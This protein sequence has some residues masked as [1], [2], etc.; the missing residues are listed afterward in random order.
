MNPNHAAVWI[1][2]ASAGELRIQTG[3]VGRAARM[4]HRLTIAMTRWSATVDWE[5]AEPVAAKLAVEVDSLEVLCGQGGLKALSAAEKSVVRSNALK[6][7][8][9]NRFPRILFVA[10]TG[11]SIAETAGGYRLTG[12][13]DIMG[14]ARQ[15]VIDLRTEELGDAWSISAESTVR[16]SDYGVKPYSLFM[17]SV[18]VADDVTVTL[19]ARHAKDD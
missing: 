16:Q 2:D 17:G 7:L 10:D 15:H 1:I 18:Q 8:N 9:A 3:V 5:G 13:L 11:G 6:S 12:T 19:T 14:T 4:G